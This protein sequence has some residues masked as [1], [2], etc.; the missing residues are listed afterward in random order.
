MMGLVPL[1]EETRELVLS[2]TT[3]EK[4]SKKAAISKPGWGSYR[5]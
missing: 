3:M 4:Y 1:L 5:N 2:L